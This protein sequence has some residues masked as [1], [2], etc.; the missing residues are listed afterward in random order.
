MVMG[1]EISKRDIP[2]HILTDEFLLRGTMQFRGVIQVII[3][4]EA[5][6]T[7]ILSQMQAQALDA[8]NVAAQMSAQEII[9]VRSKCQMIL[10]NERLKQEDY[11]L[12]PEKRPSIVY[13]SRFA[14]Q[15]N[16]AMGPHDRFE[17]V[18]DDLKGFFLPVLDANLHPLFP[19]RCELPHHVPMALIHRSYIKMLQAR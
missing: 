14:V 2:V 17:D 12:R 10:W 7:L 5:I 15:C 9:L 13:T 11:N 8:A 3:N 16:L 4:N 19:V 18:I 1:A 6:D